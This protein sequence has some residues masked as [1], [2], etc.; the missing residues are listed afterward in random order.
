MQ[1]WSSMWCYNRFVHY[2]NFTS[3]SQRCRKLTTKIT[4]NTEKYFLHR[5]LKF[6]FYLPYRIILQLYGAV[7]SKYSTSG[8]KSSSTGSTVRWS[9]TRRSSSYWH[10]RPST[11]KN[12]N[13]SYCTYCITKRTIPIIS[14]SVPGTIPLVYFSKKSRRMYFFSSIVLL[15]ITLPRWVL[16]GHDHSIISLMIGW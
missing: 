9:C 5:H 16:I 6:R 14:T 13:W 7:E 2:I 3:T 10:T 12:E 11:T 8:E 1:W 15:Q 4:K